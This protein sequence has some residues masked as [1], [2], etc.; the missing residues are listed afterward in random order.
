[1]SWART[2]ALAMALAVG[3]GAFGAHGLKDRLDPEALE[4][5]RT[6]ARYHAWHGLGLFAVSWIEHWTETPRRVRIAGWCL[7]IG[8]VLFSGSLY[9]MAL[10]GHRWLGA[11]TPLGGTAWIV[12]W[13]ILATAARKRPL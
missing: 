9:L 10:T 1:V 13:I 7:C 3:F 12:A 11:I 2:G 8:L 4:W 6:A 5:W